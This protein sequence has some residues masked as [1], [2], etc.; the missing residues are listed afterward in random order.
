MITLLAS[1]L[2]WA[3]SSENSRSLTDYLV[4]KDDHTIVLP[5]AFRSESMGTV[6]GVGA[7]VQGVFQPHTT[8]IVSAFGGLTEDVVVNGENKSENTTGAAFVLDNV[9]VP[10]SERLFFTSIGYWMDMPKQNFYFDSSNDS[11]DKDVLV[12]PVSNNMIMGTLTYVLPW[13]E[14]E[15]N[16]EALYTVKNGFVMDREGKGN[17][18]PFV[19]GRTSVGVTGFYQHQRIDNHIDALG[20]GLNVPATWNSNGLR[21]FLSHDNTDFQD[22]PSRG[23]SF[24]LKYSRDFGKY[25]SMQSWDFLEFKASKYFDMETFSFTQQNVLAFNFWTAYSFSWENDEQ[26]LPGID[27]HQSPMW[28]GPRLGGFARMRGYDSDRFAD[29]AAI[30]GT[31]EYRMILD[32]NPVKNGTFGQWAADNI[33]IDWFQLVGFVE[34]GRVHESYN[35]DLLS[36]MKYDVGLSLR[37]MAAKLPVRV[38]VAYGDE[39][40]QAWVMVKHPFDF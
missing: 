14:G 15:E 27:A 31:A 25:D 39:G 28:D 12:S 36:D 17:G 11:S 2:V 18:T 23:Y 20:A 22:N 4:Y 33:P 16:P 7:I 40:V 9:R 10:G 1:T 35:S 24:L 21:F 32:Y 6:G 38:D 13:G 26:Y 30:Y 29:K 37:A 19:T 8:L 34:A 5:Y 3:E